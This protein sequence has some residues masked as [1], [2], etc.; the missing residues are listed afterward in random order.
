MDEHRENHLGELTPTEMKDVVGIVDVGPKHLDRVSVN[1]VDSIIDGGTKKIQERRAAV[2][3]YSPD[4]STLEIMLTKEERH[5]SNHAVQCALNAAVDARAYAN[6]IAT[7]EIPA[8]NPDRAYIINFFERF[9]K[10]NNAFAELFKADILRRVAEQKNDPPIHQKAE[11][12]FNGIRAEILKIVDTFEAEH[13]DEIDQLP[14]QE[15]ESL[16]NAIGSVRKGLETDKI[17]ENFYENV[18][19]QFGN[20]AGSEYLIFNKAK[21]MNAAERIAPIEFTDEQRRAMYAKAIEGKT[22]VELEEAKFCFEHG[23]TSTV[24]GDFEEPGDRLMKLIGASRSAA[25]E[26]LA[27]ADI[28]KELPNYQKIII[29]AEK[30]A[31]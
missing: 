8:T 27:T 9:A 24:Q 18:C 15:K 4:Q 25:T 12:K 13:G 14:E 11:E 19:L 28:F 1:N 21:L 17:P 10:W 6:F 5:S 22:G 29:A 3:N 23:V 31:A 7:K 16:R 2:N 30:R 26:F 20:I